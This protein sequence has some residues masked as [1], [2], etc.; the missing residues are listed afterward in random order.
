MVVI[1][2]PLPHHGP[3]PDELQALQLSEAPDKGQES[4][5]SPLSGGMSAT[6]SFIDAVNRA[7]TGSSTPP[8]SPSRFCI[9][10]NTACIMAWIS[11]QTLYDVPIGGIHGYA[12]LL[13][14]PSPRTLRTIPPGLSP[15]SEGGRLRR[16]ALA[17][18]LP[19]ALKLGLYRR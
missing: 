13:L 3:H 1:A 18:G 5:C 11:K 10:S 16:L 2:S 6:A 17:P 7:L 8:S 14:G 12:H 4:D 19:Q 15:T 9:P